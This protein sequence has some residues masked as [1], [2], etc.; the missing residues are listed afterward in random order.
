MKIKKEFLYFTVTLKKGENI[1][2][3]LEQI[4]P[5]EVHF[6]ENN[7][8]RIRSTYLHFFK[9]RQLNDEQLTLF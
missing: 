8:I 3:I 4:P 2:N 6:P 7:V 1:D 5:K 9:D